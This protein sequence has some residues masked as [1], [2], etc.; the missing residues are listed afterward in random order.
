MIKPVR[1]FVLT[2]C[3]FMVCNYV[4]RDDGLMTGKPFSIT[5][6]LVHPNKNYDLL[7]FFGSQKEIFL[8][9]PHVS[10]NDC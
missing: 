10:I 9:V 1:G 6:R 5:K 7:I 4:K 2:V 3:M 8:N